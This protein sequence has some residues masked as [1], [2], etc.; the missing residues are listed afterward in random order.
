MTV[1]SSTSRNDYVGNGATTVYP[2]TFRIFA[3]GDLVVTQTTAAGV[4]S[5]LTLDVDYTVSGAGSAS[6]GNVTLTT[7]LPGDGTDENSSK[8]T[9][10]RVLAATQSTDL[11]SQGK[12]QA[13]VIERALDRAVMLVQQAL[14]R[15]NRC[16]SLPE[17][18][19]GTDA[20][21]ILPPLEERKGMAAGWDATGR[22][23]A[24]GPLGGATVSAAMV[25]V[26]QAA[27]LALARAAMGPWDD[28]A[29]TDVATG[30]ASTAKHGF[31]P[32]LADDGALFMSGLGTWLDPIPYHNTTR[33]TAA[34][35]ATVPVH[36]MIADGAETHIDL[37]LT[38]KGNGALLWSIPDNSGG[39]NKRGTNAVDLQKDRNSADQVAS[40]NYA[41]L[42]GTY[43]C[44]A[45]GIGS[46][47]F[48]SYSSVAGGGN[49][50]VIAGSGCD[51]SAAY[52]LASG[53]GAVTRNERSRAL[54]F[55]LGKQYD[56]SFLSRRTANATP[57]PL[58]DYALCS[59]ELQNSE[60]VV[61]TVEVVA[62]QVNSTNAAGYII[63]FVAK[64]G[65][66]AAA[67]V[68]IGQ[69]AAATH[70]DVAGW[71]VSLAADTTNGGINVNVTGTAATNVDWFAT[72]KITRTKMVT[73]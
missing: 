10:R 30:N 17:S 45:A 28:L 23:G 7:A 1:L 61:G 71:A 25:P 43:W 50:A 24:Y 40:G 32:K 60:R 18:E 73:S 16:L 3:N 49:S 31:L 39:G 19:A 4:E 65:A 64:R 6:G 27:T 21:T 26:V 57:V 14:D 48:A 22:P 67:T 68:L 9:I 11:R 2:Y 59:I 46:G 72:V 41:A 55:A 58:L 29:L 5:T 52:S 62:A 44:K 13:E 53:E 47:C 37:A 56:E 36:Q 33:T 63:H 35:N 66:N 20:T 69:T 70:E 15:A 8:L 54:G 42:V 38:P 51:A 12:V 34:P